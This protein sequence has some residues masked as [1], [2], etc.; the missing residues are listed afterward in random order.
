M[1]EQLAFHLSTKPAL[2]REDFMLSPSNAVAVA[3]LA[4]WSVWPS[5]KMALIGP[6]ASGK[7]HL[8][9]VWAAETNATVARAADLTPASVETLAAAP[10]VIEDA[11]QIAGNHTIEETLFHLHNL[12]FAIGNPLLVTAATPP[13]RWGI[14]LPDLASRM[15][16]TTITQMAAPDDALLMAVLVKLFADRQLSPAP[17]VITY[18]AARMDRSFAAARD[19]VAGLDHLALA[20]NR[21]IT[22]PLAAEFLDQFTNV[23]PSL[24]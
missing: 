3:T 16:A 4:D 14:T 1:A 23:M 18:I 6:P 5:K 2:G 15:N 7:T 13:T 12:A 20:R 11:D 8:V 21:A 17:E 24:Q 19:I 10:C 9:H 22:R